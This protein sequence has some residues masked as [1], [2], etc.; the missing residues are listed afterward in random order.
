MFVFKKGSMKLQKLTMAESIS[1]KPTK[2]NFYAK[3]LL[4]CKT[5]QLQSQTI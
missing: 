3:T 5:P 1:V 2:A 4:H